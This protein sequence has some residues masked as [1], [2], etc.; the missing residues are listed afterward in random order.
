MLQRLTKLIE[1]PPSRVMYKVLGQGQTAAPTKFEVECAT[2]ET[3]ILVA[4][5]AP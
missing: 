5:A 1:H 2:S 3:Q 4:R